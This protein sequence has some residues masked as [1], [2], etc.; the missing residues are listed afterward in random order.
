MEEEVEKRNTTVLFSYGP[1]TMHLFHHTL[2]NTRR[3]KGSGRGRENVL[4]VPC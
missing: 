4:K 2:K 3:E 1:G